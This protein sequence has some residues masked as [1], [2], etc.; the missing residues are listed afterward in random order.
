MNPLKVKVLRPDAKCGF[1]YSNGIADAA[2]YASGYHVEA[3]HP[4][5][6]NI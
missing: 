6:N 5:I 3:L 2:E 1:L 4:A